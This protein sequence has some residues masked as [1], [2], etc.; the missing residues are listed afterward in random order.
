MKRVRVA[1]HT[2]V[3][4]IFG[5]ADSWALGVTE[6]N[7]LTAAGYLV[8]DFAKDDYAAFVETAD[9]FHVAEGSV[10]EIMGFALAYSSRLVDPLK[11]WTNSLLRQTFQEPFVIV[12]QV[13]VERAHVSRGV[14]T[15]L[16]E[17]LQAATDR[18]IYAAVATEPR[19]EPSERFHRRMGFE[20]VL[21]I[22][23]PTDNIPRT[24]WRYLPMG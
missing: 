22:T 17:Y 1:R 6:A 24:V 19:N 14:G 15:A 8:S 2:D 18:P 23:P 4:S 10:G 20:P 21:E 16:Y 3:D 7:E 13:A 9:Y 5:I 11:E 12:K